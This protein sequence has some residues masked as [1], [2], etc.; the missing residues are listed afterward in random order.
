MLNFFDCTGG[1]DRARVLSLYN[2]LNGVAIVAGTLLGGLLLR[3]FGGDGYV[4]VFVGSSLL[5]AV[6]VLFLARGVGLRGGPEHDFHHV[7]LRVISLRP[8]Q[9]PAL[10][11]VVMPEGKH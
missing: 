6:A 7:F 3:S 11:P 5:R 4:A 1:H 10:R 9:G 2:L 8:G